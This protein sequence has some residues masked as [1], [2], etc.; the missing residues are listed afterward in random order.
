MFA[1]LIFDRFS[2]FPV[3]PTGFRTGLPLPHGE[4]RPPRP[5]APPRTSGIQNPPSIPSSIPNPNVRTIHHRNRRT[6][7]RSNGGVAT[8]PS[9][10]TIPSRIRSVRSERAAV[11]PSA[12]QGGVR[13]VPVQGGGNRET[14]RVGVG[15]IQQDAGGNQGQSDISLEGQE[16]R[17]K[18]GGGE[19]EGEKGFG[20]LN[21]H[22]ATTEASLSFLVVRRGGRLVAVELPSQ[23][24][25]I[26][27]VSPGVANRWVGR[28][29]SGG[30]RAL[31]DDVVRP[32]I[33]PTTIAPGSAQLGDFL[34]SFGPNQVVA[35]TGR[36]TVI[37]DRTRFP[38]KKT[39]YFLRVNS[40]TRNEFLFVLD[41]LL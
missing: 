33:H 21:D 26:A 31:G 40:V 9:R 17:G 8:K 19:G 29:S 11:A 24:A 16:V 15:R 22:G 12:G 7:R 18:G 34:A 27:M 35:A 41:M 28:N 36:R 37:D 20:S 25:T 38:G 4:R 39:V 10:G 23:K 6:A 30:V 3:A 1:P 2:K 14:V 5:G 32:L 13:G